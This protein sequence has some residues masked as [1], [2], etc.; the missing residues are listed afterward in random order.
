MTTEHIVAVGETEVCLREMKSVMITRPELASQ[1]TANWFDPYWWGDRCTNVEHGGRGAA[2]FIDENERHWF[3]R[4]YRRGGFVAKL[5]NST[6]LYSREAAVRSFAEFR[7]LSQLEA[8]ELPAPK[9]VA[10]RYIRGSIIGYQASIIMEQIPHAVP[11]HR[12][13]DISNK[14]LW[15][16][17]GQTI[18]RFHRAGVDHVDLNVKN[19]MVGPSV[20]SL[21]DFDRC[22]VRAAGSWREK[23]LERLQ[24][25]IVKDVH[26]LCAEDRPV[27]WKHFMKGYRGSS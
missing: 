16:Q 24:R 4:E 20:I 23:N 19:V 12:Y 5:S 15:E 10:G 7:L 26:H 2:W 8:L 14:Q 25:S 18:A 11:L 9:P 27:V 22:T 3:L 21:V 13:S 6:Y 1:I 17:L